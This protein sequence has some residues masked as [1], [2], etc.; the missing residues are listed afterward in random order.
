M[1]QIP[2]F[3]RPQMPLPG[4]LGRA[5][6]EDTSTVTTAAVTSARV[7]RELFGRCP[8]CTSLTWFRFAGSQKWPARV[9]EKIGQDEQVTLWTCEC[10]GTTLSE[11]HITGR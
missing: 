3:N 8:S 5:G 4:V 2:Q 6:T 10:C 11:G 9:A 7:P 1:T